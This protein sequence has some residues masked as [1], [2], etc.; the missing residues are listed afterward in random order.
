MRFRVTGLVALAFVVFMT[1]V[2]SGQDPFTPSKR[3][4]V[5]KT[6]REW[7]KQLTREQ[8]LV[9][10]LKETEPAFTGR[11]WN[12]HAKGYYTCVC[13]GAF[14]FSSAAKFESG[15]GWPSFFQPL[16]ADRIDSEVDN[17]LAEPRIEVMC[18]DCGAHLGHVFNDGPPPTGLRYCLNSASL[19]FLTE[20]QAKALAAKQKAQEEKDKQAK[21]AKDKDARGKADKPKEASPADKD[22]PAKPEA[23]AGPGSESAP[24]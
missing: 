14:L 17:K 10:R 13:C 19:R 16:A 7:S 23:K 22:A 6:D 4:K 9:A 3:R 15:T 11:Y 24:R 2:G 18:S 8:Y 1:A 20:A 5:M 12:N 21:D